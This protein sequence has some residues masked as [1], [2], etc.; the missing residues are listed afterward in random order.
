MG[1]HRLATPTY[2]GGL[3][4]GFD[5]VNNAISGT[6]A[7]ADGV[8]GTGTNAGTYFIAFGE[9]ATSSNSNR[10]NAALA[11]NCDYLDDV[12]SGQFAKLSEYTATPGAPTTSYQLSGFTMFVGT[13]SYIDNQKFRDLLVK[14]LDADGNERIDAATGEKITVT[15]IRESTNASNVIGTEASGFHTAPWIHFSSAIPAGSTR[16]VCAEQSKLV[17]VTR[18]L[19]AADAVSRAILGSHITDA[20]SSRFFLETSRRSSG[21]VLALAASRI[22]TPGYGDNIEPQSRDLTFVLDP[23]DSFGG[24]GT[25]RRVFFVAGSTGPVSLLSIEEDVTNSRARLVSGEE[26]ALRDVNMSADHPLTSSAQGNLRKFETEEPAAIFDVINRRWTVTCGDGTVSFG[27]FNGVS[28][29][30]DAITYFKANV[31]LNNGYGRGIRILLK[32]GVYEA[33]DINTAYLA[34]SGSSVVIEG[35][36]GGSKGGN[37]IIKVLSSATNAGFVVGQETGTASGELILKNLVVDTDD[38]TNGTRLVYLDSGGSVVMEDCQVHYNSIY[39]KNG[40]KDEFV[41]RA[42][43]CRFN[44]SGASRPC[45]E[46]DVPTGVSAYT[47]QSVVFTS[48]R[49]DTKPN[50]PAVQWS[51]GPSPART[52]NSIVFEGCHFNLAGATTT[53]SNFTGNPGVFALSHSTGTSSCRVERLVWKECFVDS[54]AH[55][56][57]RALLYLR[58]DDATTYVQFGHIVIDGGEWRIQPGTSELTPFYIGGATYAADP[59]VQRVTIRD[60]RMGWY[61]TTA[62]GTADYGAAPAELSAG[63]APG[64]GAF[65]ISTNDYG[66]VENVKFEVYDIL[67]QSGELFIHSYDGEFHVDNVLIGEFKGNSGTGGAPI[68]RVLLQSGSN[69]GRL[70]V[71]RLHVVSR[72]TLTSAGGAL[73]AVGII[74]QAAT[75]VS[76]HVVLNDCRVFRYKAGAGSC[77]GFSVIDQTRCNGVT[78]RGCFAEEAL[79]SGFKVYRTTGSIYNLRFDDC[80]AY[81]N[82]ARG[83]DVEAVAGAIFN[84]QYTDNFCTSNASYGIHHAPNSWTSGEFLMVSNFCTANDD[85]SNSVEIALGRGGAT[86]SPAGTLYGNVCA[87]TAATP[88]KIQFVSV[89]LPANIPLAGSQT[90]HTAAPTNANKLTTTGTLMLHNDAEAF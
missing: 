6:P 23:G 44:N 22:E 24:T 15:E 81:N 35:M 37:C 20:V 64:W 51:Y 54:G 83:I 60:V 76:D 38:Y 27:D 58:Q 29:I 86:G 56:N 4:A 11:E 18:T 49:F 50:F 30:A 34:G 88:G 40:V 66:H 8:K 74:A 31:I 48:C 90:S 89:T 28:A 21:S 47:G 71:S 7:P 45:L 36:N 14:V 68:Y 1:F 32:P 82:G 25:E 33:A 67:T 62:L 5:Y 72:N 57:N 75:A 9:D 73:A 69:D 3:P 61:S 52:M 85:A 70:L 26:L 87:G 80:R 65:F 53:L 19:T 17:D 42:N 10:A 2:L 77:H 84:A 43:R 13:T 12:V 78:F 46:I 39:L 79:G 16:L 41:V 59:R 63:G 55:A